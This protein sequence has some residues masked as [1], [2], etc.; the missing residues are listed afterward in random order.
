M[1]ELLP[2]GKIT[3]WQSAAKLFWELRRELLDSE[4]QKN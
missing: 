3:L 2:H 1:S 4:K